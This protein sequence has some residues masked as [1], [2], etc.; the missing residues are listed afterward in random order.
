MRY[1]AF[2]M[3]VAAN[4]WTLAQLRCDEPPADDLLEAMDEVGLGA[5]E[6][7]VLRLERESTPGR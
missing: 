2:K 7:Y 4:G 6:K 1:E 5:W 3:L